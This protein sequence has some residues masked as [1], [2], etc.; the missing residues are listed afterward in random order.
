MKLNKKQENV[1]FSIGILSIVLS[2]I[3]I[4]TNLRL[5]L[6][7]FLIFIICCIMSR[8]I[9]YKLF[10]RPL[11]KRIYKLK[12][13]EKTLLTEIDI[14]KTKENEIKETISNN[15]TIVQ[16]I[17]EYKKIINDLLIKKKEIEDDILKLEIRKESIEKITKQ[18][19]IV[20]RALESE[21]TTFNILSSENLKLEEQ[22]QQLQEEIDKL[23]LNKEKI[24]DNIQFKEK[25][26]LDYID[27][28]DGFEFETF[29]AELLTK[30][31]YSRSEVTKGSGDY[32]IDVIAE[33]D[34]IKYAIQ[35]K[36]YAYPVGNSAI[37]EAYSGKN[38]YECNVAIVVTNNYF[39]NSAINQ[40]KMNKVVLWDRD[41]IQ[42]MLETLT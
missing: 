23:I 25:Y 24:N 36:N 12:N 31:G 20:T 22:K 18:E 10:S 11:I 42:E 33:R 35:C 41:K 37:Q 1:A 17:N 15:Q 30:L 5:F 19:Q 32:G 34:E 29:I 4:G 14:L 6:L 2:I 28:L 16:E 9:I 7:F 27:N 21:K 40:A 3:Y 26:N 38:Y 8:R 13:V 39:T